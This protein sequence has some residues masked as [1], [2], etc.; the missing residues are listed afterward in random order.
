M[1]YAVRPSYNFILKCLFKFHPFLFSFTGLFFLLL[2][3][4]QAL[5][6]TE[7]PLLAALGADALWNYDSYFNSIWHS[8]VTLLTSNS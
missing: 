3:A 4:G 6:I 8:F 2:T 7:R 5:R 1:M